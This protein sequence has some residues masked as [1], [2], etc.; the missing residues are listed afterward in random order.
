[1]SVTVRILCPLE[2]VRIYYTLD[3]STPALTSMIFN[4]QEP[5]FL[6]TIGLTTIRA[7]GHIDGYSDGEIVEHTYS[8]VERCAKPVIT[9]SGGLFAGSIEATV[10]ST[11][12]NSQI[13]FTL[14]GISPTEDS[15]S[16]ASDG[17]VLITHSSV[18]KAIAARSGSAISQVASVVFTILPKVAN[19]V[20]SPPSEVF[21]VSATLKITCSTLNSTIYYTTDG[22][23]P[24]ESS[25]RVD[26]R[27]PDVVIDT[28][29]S[30][31]VKTF[32][33]SPTMLASDIV[34]KSFIILMR[35]TPPS[36]SPVPGTY[37]SPI[38][39]KF[40][41]PEE[42][43]EGLI[44]YT[45]DGITTPTSSSPHLNC[46][47]EITLPE[48]GRYTI[49]SFRSAEE[50]AA[51]AIVEGIYILLRP[52]YDTFPVNPNAT[53]QMK[54]EV[55]V[56]V[57]EKNLKSTGYYE[58]RYCSDRNVRG[59]LVVLHNPVGH[60]DF[61]EPHSSCGS[62]LDLPSVSG[63]DWKRKR[64][65]SSSP[66]PTVTE[67]YRD[68]INGLLPDEV[69]KWNA[70]YRGSAQS[71][72][73]VITNAGFFNITST[74]CFGDLVTHGEVIQTS[75]LH[76]VNFGIRNGSFVIGYVEAGE[77]LGPQTTN[78]SQ[79]TQ[80]SHDWVGFDTLVSG[81]VWL[82]RDSEVFVSESLRPQYGAGE[83]MTPQTAGSQFAS[84]LSAR[85]AIGF[86]AQGRLLIL[87]VEGETWVRGMSLYEFAAFAKELGFVSAINLD[88]G[89]SATMTV[90]HTLVSEPSWKCSRVRALSDYQQ[91]LHSIDHP[92]K[93]KKLD[94]RW[95]LHE[96][97][98]HEDRV[99][100]GFRYCEK[101][102]SS[103]TCAHSL[104]PP[105]VS[106]A[107][108]S[109]A[110]SR[111]PTPSPSPLPTVF[112]S[113]GHTSSHPT[114]TAATHTPPPTPL[115]TSLNS[116]TT[117]LQSE[118]V[119]LSSLTFYRLATYGLLI[120]L[121]ISM[122][123]NF[124]ACCWCCF[125]KGQDN[126]KDFRP[127]LSNSSVGIEM[128]RPHQ[129]TGALPSSQSLPRPIPHAT[130]DRVD[131]PPA[132]ST[133]LSVP[134]SNTWQS[135]FKSTGLNLGE[136][137]DEDIESRRALA[138]RS[139]VREEND[140]EDASES[141]QFFKS[142]PSQST[143][144]PSS[145]FFGSKFKSTKSKPQPALVA[146]AQQSS[147]LDELE[148]EPKTRVSSD[149]K[150]DDGEHN[151]TSGGWQKRKK[152]SIKKRSSVGAETGELEDNDAE[153]GTR[154]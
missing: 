100:D 117:L 137:S 75:N 33:T 83:D 112:P 25:L 122:T 134:T 105:K 53:Y 64:V 113:V 91:L 8:I 96:Q 14:D 39:I 54:P 43:T 114:N 82:V 35:A 61:L 90:N 135:K 108:P 147:W 136:D 127:T 46:G 42:D 152:K 40:Q 123:L 66:L 50:K 110:P 86:D 38:R 84:L 94:D 129:P 65:A 41:C 49:R 146:L 78:S 47:D 62:G 77:I 81:L 12:P 5:I 131:S 24:T 57:V 106:D 51:S 99:A 76:N 2:N 70:E 21:A 20:I 153:R 18:L 31:V 79:A 74:A 148:D 10:T 149:P 45:M 58:S 87:Q 6:D 120:A 71:D 11:T 125:S 130:S 115:P 30:H 69:E 52:P 29:G 4:P 85:T 104:A 56:F 116:T 142:P 23:D 132:H 121:L 27:L 16:I 34:T 67:F 15:P 48:H 19:P 109:L 32:A 80:E 95:S 143:A 140:E 60:F 126:D 37:T 119:P 22:S 97:R 150:A 107:V 118:G 88:G 98:V 102:V 92:A 36:L 154:A 111:Q 145:G 133:P 73:D 1:M 3:G 139:P 59:R 138:N 144:G 28:P 101:P 44:F 7:F 151:P 103:I 93:I 72:C 124:L 55:D 68:Q 26:H 63:A 128:S 17:K 141:E 13:H 9:P 89:G